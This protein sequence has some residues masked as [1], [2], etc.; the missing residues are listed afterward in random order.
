LA[1]FGVP[2]PTALREIFLE[3]LPE[4]LAGT[5]MVARNTRQMISLGLTF[6]DTNLFATR[7]ANLQTPLLPDTKMTVVQSALLLLT[8][9]TATFL[10]RLDR[11][12]AGILMEDKSTL[13]A[14]FLG[15]LTKTSLS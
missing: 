2:L 5:P 7:E 9:H 13:P 10:E 8:P 6:L 1:L 15:L 14:T 12:H 4:T 3:K 11:E